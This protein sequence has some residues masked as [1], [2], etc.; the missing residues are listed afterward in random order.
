MNQLLQL[1]YWLYNYCTDFVINVANLLNL[2]YYEV[3]FLLF[4]I[5]YPALIFGTALLYLIQRWKLKQVSNSMN[6]EQIQ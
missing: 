4:I 1:A 6:N 3:N 5:G 2:S